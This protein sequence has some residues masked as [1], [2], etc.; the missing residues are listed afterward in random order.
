MLDGLSSTSQDV[1]G[2]RIGEGTAV[3]QHD[4]VSLL[5]GYVFNARD[6]MGQKAMSLMETAIPHCPRA[7]VCIDEDCSALQGQGQC[8]RLHT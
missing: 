1:S 5:L 8:N 7:Y 2:D 4:R 3:G 6:E